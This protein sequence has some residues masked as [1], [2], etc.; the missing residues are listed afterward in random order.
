MEG[1]LAPRA[2]LGSNLVLAKKSQLSCTCQA[3]N[4][5]KPGSSSGS[6]FTPSFSFSDLRS[7][8]FSM[9]SGR[10]LVDS[11]GTCRSLAHDA[12]ENEETG[13]VPLRENGESSLVPLRGE[14]L[15]VR[16]FQTLSEELAMGLVLQAASGT[17]WTT[18]SGLQGPSIL[19]G[20]ESNLSA[21]EASGQT[22]PSL[23]RS[24]RRRMRVE[25]TCNVC[26]ERTTRAINPHAY[27]DG[28]VFVQCGGC[29]IFHKLVDNLKLF[30]EMKG[31]VFPKTMYGSRN[32]SSHKSYDF[33][34]LDHM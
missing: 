23:S 34:G 32:F 29:N 14:R 9:T 33:L 13:L 17:G 7:T 24:P 5:I 8:G 6:R 15:P 30:H 4:P 18:G 22:W 3:S 11:A 27:T 31:N 12:K 26:G 16:Q 25:F 1:L 28:T 10:P 2:V 20:S 19:F 21:D